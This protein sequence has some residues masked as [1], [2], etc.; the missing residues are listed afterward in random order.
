MDIFQD[1][2]FYLHFK[3]LYAI[4]IFQL[5]W[6]MFQILGPRNEILYDP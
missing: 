6:K 2:I 1:S 4:G 5:I 3:V